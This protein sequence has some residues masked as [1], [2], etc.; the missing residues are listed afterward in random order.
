[1]KS[2][3]ISKVGLATVAG[4]SEVGLQDFILIALLGVWKNDETRQFYTTTEVSALIAHTF[5]AIRRKHKDNV[6][7]YF[8]QDFCNRDHEI[9]SAPKIATRKYRLSNTGY[10]M[11]ISRLRALLKA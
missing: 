11:A 7:R 9:S 5:P 6:S 3:S 4:I 8:N 2:K 1:M 10:G